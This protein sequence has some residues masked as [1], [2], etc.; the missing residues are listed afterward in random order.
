MHNDYVALRTLVQRLGL[1]VFIVA[2]LLSASS[3][4]AAW[5]FS[6]PV[7]D[8]TVISIRKTDLLVE[9]QIPWMG[10]GDRP[11]TPLLRL[12]FSTSADLFALSKAHEYNV[13]YSLKT[14]GKKVPDDD[15]KKYGDVYWNGQKV[16]PYTI[17]SPEYAAVVAK[18]GSVTYQVFFQITPGR[19]LN[20][21][22]LALAGGNML[23]GTLRSNEATLPNSSE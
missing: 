12:D 15:I 13:Y 3:A 6:G 16:S 4:N 19:P 9:K 1:Y 5:P 22:C 11:A 7:K 18:H 2:A 23:G 21:L 8:V 17:A 10:K 20:T 14:C